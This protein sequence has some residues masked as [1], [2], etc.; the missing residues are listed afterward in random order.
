M[1]PEPE[2]ATEKG[3]E[4]AI[5]SV[6]TE[7]LEARRFR[8][9]VLRGFGLDVAV[10]S[11]KEGISRVAFFEIKAY[12]AHHGRCG[13]G[14]GEGGGN[15]IKLMYDEALQAPRVQNVLDI[16]ETSIRWI[17]GDCS[18]PIGSPRFVFFTCNQ[19]QAAV[20]NGVRTGKQNNLRL[21]AFNGCWLAWPE[22]TERIGHFLAATA[23]QSSSPIA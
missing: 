2:F 17:L 10:F 8:V 23:Y 6:A 5:A 21:S 19:A 16:F 22:L 13:I 12:A 20:M 15:Q 9:V 4:D 14:D 7:V 11:S 1:I 18:K 3:L